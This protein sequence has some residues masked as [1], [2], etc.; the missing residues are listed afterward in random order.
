MHK[1]LW[2]TYQKI[3]AKPKEEEKWIDTL[4]KNFARTIINSN[5]LYEE[6]KDLNKIKEYFIQKL[7]QNKEDKITLES[8]AWE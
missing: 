7:K 4:L 6:V 1:L 3:H 5:K 2:D 8:K